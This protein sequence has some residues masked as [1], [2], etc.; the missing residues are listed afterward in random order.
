MDGSA[1]AVDGAKAAKRKEK[2]RPRSQAPLGEELEARQQW[3]RP[4]GGITGHSGCSFSGEAPIL[5]AQI[6]LLHRRANPFP[7]YSA[8]NLWAQCLWGHHS[9]SLTPA[10]VPS[11]AQRRS[12]RQGEPG[13]DDTG[14]DGFLSPGTI[15]RKPKHF[16]FF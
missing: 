6:R 1:W 7:E 4:P 12:A 15:K 11:L 2:R 3:P 16:S 10:F 5:G 8:L 13:K 14:Q 9:V